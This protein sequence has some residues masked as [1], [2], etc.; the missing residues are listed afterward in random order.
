MATVPCLLIMAAGVLLSLP[1][2]KAQTRPA[3][4]PTAEA[5]L[6]ERL[7][8]IRNDNADA[9]FE[10]AAWAQ[11][12]GL[13][14]RAGQ[15]LEN[16]VATSPDH[17]RA[18][19]ALRHV[20]VADQWQPFPKAVESVGARIASGAV[21]DSVAESL[22]GLLALAGTQE[23]K[24]RIQEL[25]AQMLLRRGRFAEARQAYVALSTAAPVAQASRL[26][27][28]A[29]VL[30]DHPDGL[31]VLTEAYP[32]ASVLLGRQERVV[33]AGPAS[34]SDPLVLEAALR[35][36]AAGCIQAGSALLSKARQAE[37][38]DPSAAE[39]ACR[40]AL[41]QF[42]RADALLPNVARG[43]KVD[44][45]RQRIIL[46]RRTAEQTAA[47]FDA[48]V[49]ALGTRELSRQTYAESLSRMMDHL[50]AVESDLG[51]IAQLAQPYAKDLA[52]ELEWAGTDR[53]TILDMQEMLREE[54][55]ESR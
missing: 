35:D 43:Y 49:A 51:A 37:S 40:M 8:A 54:I 33:A 31:Y 22:R 23:E 14:G 5:Q 15:L 24:A 6:E 20:R 26:A 10:A 9:L 13:S 21:D 18:R 44:V 2:G 36:R 48:E 7:T 38:A 53:R 50:R 34:L 55:H 17:A 3:S 25:Q 27:C 30:A 4:L 46:L 47:Q 39:A 28:A 45:I 11:S 19:A 16:V 12:H 32:P 41:A 42:D 52:V 1:A 29:E